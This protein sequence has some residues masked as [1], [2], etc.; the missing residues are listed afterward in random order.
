[1]IELGSKIVLEGFD[2]IDRTQLVVV[3]KIVGNY[4]K[5][6]FEDKEGFEKVVV[7]LN[8]NDKF[9]VGVKVTIKGEEKNSEMSDV[10]LFF[11]LTSA[12]EKLR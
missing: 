11:A 10:N 3:K 6:L 8:K 2:D 5:K 1:M 4:T 12:L 7:T 9:N